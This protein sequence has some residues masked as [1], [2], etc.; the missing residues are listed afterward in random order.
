MPEP[1]PSAPHAAAAR[2][3]VDYATLESRAAGQ[4][5][6]LACLET[7]M[8]VALYWWIAI[9]WDTHW[10]LLTSVFIAPLLLLRSPESIKL[11]VRWFLKDWLGFQDYARWPKVRCWLWLHGVAILSGMATYA[12]ARW[13]CGLWL[14]DQ[15]VWALWGSLIGC[16]SLAFG[17]VIVGVA[18]GV[19]MGVNGGEGAVDGAV[20]G[21]GAGMVAALAGGVGAVVVVV[22]GAGVGVGVGEGVGVE[23]I[24][25][26]AVEGKFK[27][28]ATV[29]YA[30][31]SAVVGAAVF[32][33]VGTVAGAGVGLSLRSLVFRVA[34][35]LRHLPQGMRRMA[36]NWQETNFW[37]DS[38]VPA[39]L[40]PGMR[41]EHEHFTFDGFVRKMRQ[42]KTPLWRWVVW[43]L[44][45][46]FFFLPAFLYRLNIK[47][48]C[49]FWWPLAF[50]LKPIERT[51]DA[52]AQ[53]HELTQ[54]YRNPVKLA[55]LLIGGLILIWIFY[56]YY[57]SS[58][59]L[60]L[61][62]PHAV[63]LPI[64][65]FIGLD[66]RYFA[67]WHWALFVLEITG[68]VMLWLGSEALSYH[69]DYWQKN[70]PKNVR[71][72][73]PTMKWLQRFQL[74]SFL[75]FIGFGLGMCLISYPEARPYMP[76]VL[77]HRLDTFYHAQEL[78]EQARLDSLSDGKN[79]K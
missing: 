52:E 6:K 31:L 43:P 9:R 4:V 3:W 21:A 12:F 42:E 7:L 15:N 53:H 34:A 73:L 11:G 48:T 64:K 40:M 51:G 66:W 57:N 58:A 22:V 25:M 68:L 24:I 30:A 28:E 5:S 74:I 69:R 41:E 59:N 75:V 1:A 35:T 49:W 13:L 20:D 77:L 19:T 29:V 2:P 47:A 27:D 60:P 10:H 26:G 62:D 36:E 32:A 38:R 37:V 16:C 72:K 44:L 8:A 33:V 55:S 65:V 14:V 76:D 17:I 50:L 67:P 18:M 61:K 39:E 23:V 70:P 46:T 56:H 71:W 45:A 79:K 63:W 54:V 78:R